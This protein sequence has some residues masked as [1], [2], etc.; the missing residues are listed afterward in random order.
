MPLDVEATVDANESSATS[1][2]G[3]V[4]RFWM[5]SVVSYPEYSTSTAVDACPPELAPVGVKNHRNRPEVV[6]RA[7]L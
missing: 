7:L 1:V 5:V 3:S 2:G 6:L 4:G